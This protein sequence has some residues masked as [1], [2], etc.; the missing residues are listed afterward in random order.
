M[1][2]DTNDDMKKDLEALKKDMAKFRDDLGTTMGDLGSCSHEKLIATRENLKNA[3]NSFEGV[4]S[5]KLKAAKDYLC[6]KEEKAA[7]A[8]REKI[9]SRPL[10][11]VAISFFVGIITAVLVRK[12]K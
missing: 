4:A 7:E 6:E 5:E 2:K 9:A 11:A 3:I 10:T 12:S 8:S 1:S